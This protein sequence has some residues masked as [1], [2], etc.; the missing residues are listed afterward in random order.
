MKK[1]FVSLILLV[2]ITSCKK[3]ET[4]PP[5]PI[6]QTYTVEYSITASARTNTTLSGDVTYVSKTSAT[7]TANFSAGQWTV[8]EREWKLKAGDVVGFE[9]PLLNLGSYEARL[10]VNGFTVG[11][12]KLTNYAG[13]TPYRIVLQYKF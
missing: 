2:S 7:A 9:A 5:A 3:E 13:P 12:E 1:L 4:A 11:Y 8:T 10:I 6:E